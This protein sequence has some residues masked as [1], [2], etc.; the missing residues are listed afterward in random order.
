MLQIEYRVSIILCSIIF[1]SIIIISGSISDREKHL[2]FAGS[3][4]NVHTKYI[5]KKGSLCG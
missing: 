4:D 2:S 5:Q 3:D 1:C